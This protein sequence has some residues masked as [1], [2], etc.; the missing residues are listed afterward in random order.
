MSYAHHPNA[1]KPGKG[2]ERGGRVERLAFCVHTR[3]WSSVPL[4]IQTVTT[5]GD[6]LLHK[7]RVLLVKCVLRHGCKVSDSSFLALAGSDFDK[8]CTEPQSESFDLPPPEVL[9]VLFEV[10]VRLEKV[11]EFG[12]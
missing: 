7:H 11:T 8:L 1:S 5:E 2:D 10:R 4:L 3:E 12:N 6:F 9:L